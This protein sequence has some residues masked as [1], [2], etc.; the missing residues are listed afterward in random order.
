MSISY[1]DKLSVNAY[2]YLS[3]VTSASNYVIASAGDVLK[4]ET[5]RTI[6]NSTDN[7]YAGEISWDNGFVYV[8]VATNTWK[9]ATLNTW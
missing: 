1:T 3:P 7:G 5:P 6:T 9:R 8:C 2:P 4:L